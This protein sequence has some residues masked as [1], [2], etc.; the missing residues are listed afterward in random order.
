M[1]A[2]SIQEQMDFELIWWFFFSDDS[3]IKHRIIKVVQ[4]EIGVRI[5]VKILLLLAITS[6]EVTSLTI[7]EV[8]AISSVL[9]VATISVVV[10]FFSIILL[11]IVSVI[12]PIVSASVRVFLFLRSLVLSFVCTTHLRALALSSIVGF[13]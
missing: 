13:F 3:L 6:I 11:S 4:S 7:S 9:P 2:L 10:S 1:L 8:L 5:V 12:V